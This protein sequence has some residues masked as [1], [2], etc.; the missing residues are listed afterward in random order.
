MNNS[1]TPA[2]GWMNAVSKGISGAAI[3]TAL[4]CAPAMSA[5]I[6][7]HDMTVTTASQSHDTG[8][9]RMMNVNA[10]VSNIIASASATPTQDVGSRLQF[11]SQFGSGKLGD[12]TE[13]RWITASRTLAILFV[14]MA[15]VSLR[16]RSMT[17][18][19]NRVH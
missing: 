1:R 7:G 2:S 6:H 13:D 15:V 14:A 10:S 4:V 9:A 8:N 19:S 5:T 16:I 12:D 3:A 17:E 11:A 18:R